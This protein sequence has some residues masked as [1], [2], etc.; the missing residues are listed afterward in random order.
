M[1]FA[2]QRLPALAAAAAH[3]MHSLFTCKGRSRG[4]CRLSQRVADC[5]PNL[6]VWGKPPD[7]R[8][9]EAEEAAAEAAEAAAREEE[10]LLLR[11][12]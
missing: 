11:C 4:Q 7:G 9:A 2:Y 3:R 6:S 1:D 8:A 10:E 12:I 5:L